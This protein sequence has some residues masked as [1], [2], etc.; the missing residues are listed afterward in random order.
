MI[1]KSAAVILL[2]FS[3]LTLS[4]AIAYR[5]QIK[6]TIPALQ[7]AKTENISQTT[8]LLLPGENNTKL[9]L[10]IPDGYSINVFAENLGAV[11]DLYLF[12]NTWL[13]ASLPQDGKIIAFQKGS[14]NSKKTVLQGMSYPHGISSY[15]EGD[16]PSCK[17]FIAEE[18]QVVSYDIN[19][20]S[21][22]TSNKKT[23]F[24]L[25]SGA[26]HRTRSLLI[27]NQ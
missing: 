22:E 5:R 11:R 26:G 20:K 17:L 10:T 15:C 7:P 19:P 12:N 2:I 16:N 27:T 14:P 8:P 4:L 3:L 13:L 1:Q 24:S 21:L 18:S 25:P 6:N 23:L 9:P